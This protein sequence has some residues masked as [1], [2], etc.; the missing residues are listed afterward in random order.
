MRDACGSHEYSLR[1]AT[2]GSSLLQAR[3][4]FQQSRKSELNKSFPSI[5]ALLNPSPGSE[6]PYS[7][8][9]ILQAV[10]SILIS[11]L[12]RLKSTRVVAMLILRGSLVDDVHP[13]T[14]YRDTPRVECAAG[15]G[16]TK[17]H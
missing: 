4:N 7:S 17:T 13:G 15:R 12:Y 5:D 8:Y 9:E 10:S 1:T 11:Q 2:F 6:F 14:R 16:D 3:S